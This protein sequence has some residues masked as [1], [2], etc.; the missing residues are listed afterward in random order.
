M[1]SGRRRFQ[2]FQGCVVLDFPLIMAKKRAVRRSAFSTGW[3]SMRSIMPREVEV[4]EMAATPVKAAF[5]D[6]AVFDLYFQCDLVAAAWV[7]SSFEDGVGCARWWRDGGVSALSA[8]S[9][10]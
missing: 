3:P 2:F 8:M 6:D 5:F 1:L 9:S 7:S 4:W 10:V